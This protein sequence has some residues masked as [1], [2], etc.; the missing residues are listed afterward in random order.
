MSRTDV[1]E[2]PA[3]EEVEVD[4]AF[5][6]VHDFLM[7]LMA[8]M[9]VDTMDEIIDTELG[10]SHFK[11]LLILSRHC[12]PLSVNEL[13]DELH[14]SLAAT[15][16]AVDKLVGLELVTRREDQFDRRI[17]RV[18]LASA[19]E[20]AVAVAVDRRQDS[21]RN[22]VTT[23]PGDLR[24]NLKNALLPILDGDYLACSPLTDSQ[25]CM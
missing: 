3:S 19:G 24:A 25:A 1:V 22:L 11:A 6:I 13:S 5:Q 23:L 8:G 16:R 18:S 10:F 4:E 2:H 9:D 15:G 17:K 14:L 21:I 20:K 7:R 12:R